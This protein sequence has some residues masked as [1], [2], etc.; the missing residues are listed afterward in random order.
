MS[1]YEFDNRISI[2]DEMWSSGFCTTQHPT[3]TLTLPFTTVKNAVLFAQRLTEF[4]K[5][6]E[7]NDHP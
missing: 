3:V 5:M 7:S 2:K 6:E 4:L 1:D